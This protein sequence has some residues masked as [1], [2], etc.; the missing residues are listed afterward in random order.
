MDSEE[1]RLGAIMFTDVVG[2][3]AM[4]S[5]DEGAALE[6]LGELRARLN[7]VFP[8]FRGRVVKTMGDGYLVEFAS[9]VEAVNCAVEVQG[10]MARFNSSRKGGQQAM[11]RVG[12]HVGDVVHSGGDV[13]GDAVNVASRVE[14]QALPGGICVTR[15]VFDQVEGKV[16]W[17]IEPLGTRELR[18][19]PNPVELFAV[20]AEVGRAA[21]SPQ[22]PRRPNR[23]A[24]LPFSNLSPDPND[25]YFADGITEELIST[26]SQVRELSVISRSSAVHYRDTA[27]PTKEI[28]RELGVGAILEGSVRKAGNR[29]RIAA[30]LIE[31][32]ADRYVWSQSYDR[33]ITDVFKVQGE[34]AEQVAQGLRVQ[35]LSNERD[36]L[37][38]KV[39]GSPEAFNLYL[40]GRFYLNERT[41]DGVKKAL[42]YFGEAIQADPHFA[43]AYSGIADC[44]LIESDY[45]WVA[46]AKAGE[47]ARANA[48]KALS[49][50]ASLA[51][52]HA[53]LGLGT[54]NHR[55]DFEGGERELRRAIELNP[56]Y[57]QA[58]HWYSVALGFQR[59][60]GEGLEMAQKALAL[61][62]F[63][64]VLRQSTGVAL[65]GL[66]RYQE[67]AEMFGKVADENPDLPSIHYWLA[68]L[69]I[70]QSRWAEAIEEA[71]RE[72]ETDNFD[73]GSK[74][75]LA[76]TLSES[77]DQSGAVKLLDEVL[78]S[79]SYFS[80][81]TVAIVLL[82]LGRRPEAADWLKKAVEERDSA[83]LYFMSSPAY[84]KYSALPEAKG[85][86][87]QVDVWK[88]LAS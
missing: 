30:Q 66:G 23:I 39:T 59:R 20:Q 57:A 4:S 49:I 5:E 80:P 64:L 3:T 13:L 29:V 35:L 78:G 19:L 42:R 82:S 47:M 14:P 18:N 7:P 88:S 61:D 28:G 71:R 48:L 32:D 65:L 17:L 45:G 21:Q 76:F 16:K 77:G 15:Q 40:K 70:L 87:E 31:V 43:K 73:P 83:L 67:A 51:E 75:D 9:A 74:L 79:A 52:A 33:D 12:I 38:S 86:R 44:H 55:W 85:V 46:P 10:E 8:R 84:L 53:S 24:I 54:V 6:L 62:P 72:V 69:H 81:T 41:E 26:L 1:R 58:Y 27:L 63:S 25:R 2:Y 22:H 36:Q 11:V 56:N 68:M 50:D 37:E 60:Y 34:I